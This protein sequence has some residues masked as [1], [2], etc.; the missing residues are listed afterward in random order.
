MAVVHV[1]N[2]TFEKEVMQAEGKVLVDFWAS[3]CGPCR[4]LGPVIDQL[5]NELTDVK[6]CKI[7]VDANQELAGKYKVETIPTLV[8]LE[9]GK[10]IKRSVGVQPKP[11][12]L[13]MLK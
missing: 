7:D 10:E 3:W 1:T 9:G 12:I 6:V 11:A 13:A 8:V 2:E 5:G 4:M